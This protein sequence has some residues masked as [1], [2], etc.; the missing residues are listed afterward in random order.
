MSVKMTIIYFMA[1][2][3]ALFEGLPYPKMMKHFSDFSQ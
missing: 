3:F 2:E 1:F